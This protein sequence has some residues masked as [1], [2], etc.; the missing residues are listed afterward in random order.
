MT[1]LCRLLHRRHHYSDV[2]GHWRWA[3]G[4]CWGVTLNPPIHCQRCEEA[5][6]GMH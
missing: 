3:L 2:G 4:V 6:D 1:M 5:G